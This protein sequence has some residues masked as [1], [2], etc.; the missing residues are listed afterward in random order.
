V[1]SPDFKTY[2]TGVCIDLQTT[3]TV[4]LSPPHEL[5]AKF[6]MAQLVFN[7]F[8]LTDYEFQAAQCNWEQYWLSHASVD[9]LRQSHDTFAVLSYLLSSNLSTTTGF[10]LTDW[11]A[12]SAYQY[13]DIVEEDPS[14]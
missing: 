11:L 13:V 8:D 2:K 5:R 4:T 6:G 12:K 14:A 3:S 9:P 10:N 7:K 1:D